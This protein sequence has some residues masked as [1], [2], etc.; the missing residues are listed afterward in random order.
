MGLRSLEVEQEPQPIGQPAGRETRRLRGRLVGGLS[1]LVGLVILAVY[2]WGIANGEATAVTAATAVLVLALGEYFRRRLAAQQYRWEK[3]A[4]HYETFIRQLRAATQATP[5][6]RVE[7]MPTTEK[8]VGEFG[9][10]LLL[11]GTPRVVEAWVTMRRTPEGD[12]V[13]NIH[14]YVKLLRAIRQ[15]FGHQDWSLEDRDLLRVVMNEELE[16]LTDPESGS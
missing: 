16:T 7:L 9:D 4:P 10:S 13:A 11:W 8:I 6:Q 12:P 3:I 15:E 5:E 1:G 14:A 2:I